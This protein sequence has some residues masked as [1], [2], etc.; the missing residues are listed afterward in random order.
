MLSKTI[1][2]N[3][4]VGILRISSEEDDITELSFY[5]TDSKISEINESQNIPLPAILQQCV[6]QLDQYFSGKIANFNLGLAQNGTVFQKNVWNALCTIPYGKTI[7][8]IELSKRL[9]NSKA[10]RAVGTANGKNNIA[11]IVPCHRVIGSNGSLVGYAGD[12]WRKH[13]L[14]NHEAKYAHGVQMLFQ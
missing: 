9:G 8:Y 1:Y 14:L 13:W 3:S 5:Q 10:I 7:S 12:L 2:Y 11:I 4:P 6:Q